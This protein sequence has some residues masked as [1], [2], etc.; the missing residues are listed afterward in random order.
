M[1]LDGSWFCVFD[2]LIVN[3]YMIIGICNVYFCSKRP[4][5]ENPNK[6]VWGLGKKV[7]KLIK[8]NPTRIT[9]MHK[10]IANVLQIISG[11]PIEK[12]LYLDL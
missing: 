4:F 6:Q 2:G 5:S 10:S 8:P 12:A 3:Y 11:C 9:P 1:L 7:L